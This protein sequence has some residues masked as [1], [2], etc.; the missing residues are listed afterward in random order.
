MFQDLVLNNGQTAKY[1]HVDNWDR[2]VYRLESRRKVCCVD[3]NGTNLHT[4][5]VSGEPES[6]LNN[7]Y[8]PRP[9]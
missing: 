2:P 7:D 9:L 3:L 4:M 5:T 8:Q 1:L 6:P